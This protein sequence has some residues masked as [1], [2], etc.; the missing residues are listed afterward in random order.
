MKSFKR[1]T[2]LRLSGRK[3]LRP[4][5]LMLL[6][7]SAALAQAM[8]VD[9]GVPDLQLHIDNTFKY[10]VAARVK[11]RSARLTEGTNLDDGDR[12]FAK[13]LVSNR[14]DW[15]GELDAS[16]GAVGLR[17]SAAAWYDAVYN[18]HTDNDSPATYNAIGGSNREFPEAT[19][20]LHGR[21][22]EVLDL[23]AYLKTDVDGMG[24]TARAGRHTLI[25]G[26]SLFFGAN[27]IANAQGPV[28][29]VKL[30][31][32]PSS[33]FKEILRPVEQVSGVLQVR[34]NLTLGAYYQ[35]RWHETLIPAVGSYLSNADFVGEG[36]QRLI[37]GAPIVPGGGPAAFWR[38]PDIKPKD[39]GQ[40]GL[41]VRWTPENSN[42][43]LG[44]YAAR[45]HDKTPYLY[46]TPAA[47]PDLA[48][49]RV[50]TIQQV[51]HQGTNTF[52]ASATTSIGQL[53]LAAEASIRK[54]ASLV[55]DPQVVLSGG[56]N[57]DQPLYAVGTTGH[58][59]VS[60]IYVLTQTP[61]WDA[62]ALLAELAWNRRIS[63]SKNPGAID[64]NTT[65]DAAA[66]R[67]LFEPTYF[68]VLD[69]LDVGVPLGLGYNFNG[70]SS[71]I[72]AFNGGSS[73]GGDWSLGLNGTYRTV[74]QFGLAYTH[75]FGGEDALLTP[76]N[77]AA[78][79][80]S[81]KQ[82]LKDRNFIALSL[83]RAF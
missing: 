23:F 33:Q 57:A 28:D 11:D 69:G 56:N 19:R 1:R 47:A 15:L 29:L 83:K 54:N 37:V 3:Y 41:Q 60:G 55:S 51:Y 70:R 36:A 31:T 74:W 35:L 24:L 2:G 26:E 82:S 17:T 68:Q 73:R 21:K 65:R 40:G 77:A 59:Q 34:P 63:V 38:G 39:S 75:Y 61:F 27:G 58:A 80:L 22:A 49:G 6:P 71:A 53:N 12:N 42:W 9:T 81:Y 20:R 76:P 46:L 7:L 32:V 10:S 52:G 78:P 5:A 62:G 48:S 79:V 43:E 14:V 25:Y 16:Y 45:Y 50:G 8:E 18:G 4:A 30:L 72:F 66:L 67:L 64:P 44:L 13:G